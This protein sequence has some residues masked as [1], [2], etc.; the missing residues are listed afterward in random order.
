MRAIPARVSKKVASL[1]PRRRREWHF[2][3]LSGGEDLSRPVGL[4]YC[5]PER[6]GPINAKMV[7]DGHPTTNDAD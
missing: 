5:P 2:V 4:R 1:A 7:L 6:A 3:F